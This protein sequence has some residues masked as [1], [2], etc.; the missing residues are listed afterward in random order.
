[1]VEIIGCG[2]ERKFQEGKL[3]LTLSSIALTETSNSPTA[4]KQIIIHINARAYTNTHAQ[5]YILPEKLTLKRGSR[6]LLKS[7]VSFSTDDDAC[8]SSTLLPSTPTTFLRSSVSVLSAVSKQDMTV[9]VTRAVFVCGVGGGNILRQTGQGG[10]I[11]GI[12][13]LINLS[14]YC[15]Q[16]CFQTRESLSLTSRQNITQGNTNLVTF[17]PLQNAQTSNHIKDTNIARQ[18]HFFFFLSYV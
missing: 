17:F 16:S 18:Q 6:L 4:T 7:S 3:W 9:N 14:F 15:L 5:T 10:G 2:F 13:R 12:L 8:Q 1:M 11:L